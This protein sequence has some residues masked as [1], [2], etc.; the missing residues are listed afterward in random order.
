MECGVISNV[1]ISQVMLLAKGK[2]S[3]HECSCSAALCSHCPEASTEDVGMVM[4]RQ[5]IPYQMLHIM[6]LIQIMTVI[7]AISVFASSSSQNAE[8]TRSQDH[9]SS[10][11]MQAQLPVT[12]S[13]LNNA[14]PSQMDLCQ[15]IQG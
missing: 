2:N 12:T 13:A 10:S 15:Y 9:H 1:F 11:H 3:D 7:L 5:V 8:R 6:C 14:S 4:N